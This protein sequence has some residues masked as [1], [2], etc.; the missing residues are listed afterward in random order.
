[1]AMNDEETVALIADGHTFG[2]CHGA[3][4]E[5]L[6]GPEPE[7]AD[8]TEQGLGWRSGHGAGHGADTITSGIEGAWTAD[9]VRWDN[10]YFDVLFGYEWEC[11]KSP[12]GAYQWVPKDGAGAD[13]VPDAHDRAKRHAPIMTT[14]DMALRWTRSTS[15]SRG[16]STRTRTRSPM[17]S[18]APGSR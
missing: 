10:G 6:V 11:V 16:A 13:L 18:H 3:G 14:A 7:A 8:M 17:P 4:P 2:K 15:P 1:M 12:A 5:T 9:P